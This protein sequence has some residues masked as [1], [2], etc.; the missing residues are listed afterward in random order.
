M[1]LVTPSVCR[2]VPIAALCLAADPTPKAEPARPHAGHRLPSAEDGGAQ[3][4]VPPGQ[5]AE[6]K[7]YKFRLERIERCGA[8]APGALRGEVSWIG[9]FL[10]VEAK[11]ELFVSARDLELRRGGVILSAAYAYQPKLPG[12]KPTLVA[13]RMRGGDRLAGFALFEVPKAFRVTTED[14]IVL[15]YRPTRW[16]GA[17]RAEVPIPEC[18]DACATQWLS[19][20]NKPDVS[21]SRS[22]S[23]GPKL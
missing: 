17:R 11:D 16:G 6:N 5:W 21:A 14:P 10:T 20:D 3:A 15:S 13:R 8:A 9:A 19:D 4:P 1:P 23:R 18:L 22:R 7:L 2:V 12:C